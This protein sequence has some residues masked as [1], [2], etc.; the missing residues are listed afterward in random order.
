MVMLLV[1]ACV[2][3]LNAYAVILILLRSRINQVPLYRPMLLNVGL[4]LAPST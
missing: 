4:S 3:L 1:G 2:L